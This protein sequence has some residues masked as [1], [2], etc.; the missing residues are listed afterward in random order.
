[1]LKTLFRRSEESVHLYDGL[2]LFF[3][4]HQI[5]SAHYTALLDLSAVL[6]FS[7]TVTELWQTMPI[8]HIQQIRDMHGERKCFFSIILHTD[9]LWDLSG[10]RL[11]S[12][13]LPPSHDKGVKVRDILN[14]DESL[15]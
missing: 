4:S 12:L 8:I 13:N 11:I 9:R 3:F 1:M 5:A 14:Y 6:I 15:Y 2:F 10:V 7:I